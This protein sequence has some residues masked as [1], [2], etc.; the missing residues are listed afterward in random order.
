MKKYLLMLLLALILFTSCENGI[1]RKGKMVVFSVALDY[2]NSPAASTL[3]GTIADAKEFTV[4]MEQTMKARGFAIETCYMLQ[5]G[6]DCLTDAEY[7]PIKDN[8][9]AKLDEYSKSLAPDD[10]LVFYYSG[11]G[12]TLDQGKTGFLVT[13]PTKKE[14]NYGIFDMD[15]LYK[16]MDRLPCNVILII[17]ACYSGVFNNHADTPNVDNVA[18]WQTFMKNREYENVV[19][20]AASQSNQTSLVSITETKEGTYE[21]HGLMTI[22]LLREIGWK[23]STLE[24]TPTII[25]GIMSNVAGY[26]A[27]PKKELKISTIFKNM[28]TNWAT[29]SQ[30]PDI[31]VSFYDMYLIP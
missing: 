27:Y 7:Y 25:N 12:E 8:I 30:T 24:T 21:R 16:Y 1:P 10:M 29:S 5:E 19:T 22:E 23:H 15:T 28:M 6:E 18:Q 2:A 31:N 11:H 4:A 26:L 14:P 17:D 3:S 20:L 13:A 9:Y